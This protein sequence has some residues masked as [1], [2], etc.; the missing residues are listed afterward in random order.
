MSN[1]TPAPSPETA[2]TIKVA[3]NNGENRRFKLALRELQANTLPDKVCFTSQPHPRLREHLQPSTTGTYP[4][5]GPL[6]S[7]HALMLTTSLIASIFVSRPPNA[8]G[9]VRTFLRQ[10]WSLHQA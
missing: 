5:Y 9:D 7:I 6:V 1:A 8:D 10:R 3:L 4:P 2:I